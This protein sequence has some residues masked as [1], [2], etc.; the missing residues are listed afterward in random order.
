MYCCLDGVD[1]TD[2]VSLVCN[3][4]DLDTIAND[5]FEASINTLVLKQAK[6][7]DPNYIIL[8]KLSVVSLVL[9]EVNANQDDQFSTIWKA[10][11]PKLQYITINKMNMNNLDD[12]FKWQQLERYSK[13]EGI[14]VK[15]SALNVIDVHMSDVLSN[16][17]MLHT[18]KIEGKIK[19]INYLAFK[20]SDDLNLQQLD[21]SNNIISNLRWLTHSSLKHLK[22]LNLANNKLL[23]LPEQLSQALPSLQQ[24]DLS[25]NNFRFITWLAIQPLAALN[26]VR[27]F[28]QRQIAPLMYFTSEMSWIK[29]KSKFDQLKA[30]FLV[31][32]IADIPQYMTNFGKSQFKHF[33]DHKD[34]Q[35]SYYLDQIYMESTKLGHYDYGYPEDKD[36]KERYMFGGDVVPCRHED[37]FQN[38]LD[39]G[40]CLKNLKHSSKLK[41]GDANVKQIFQVSSIFTRNHYDFITTS[42]G[43]L[44]QGKQKLFYD[45]L[46]ELLDFAASIDCYVIVSLWEDLDSLTAPG[47]VNI[48]V[49]KVRLNQLLQ[50]LRERI[51]SHPALLGFDVGVLLLKD[52]S[53]WGEG[54]GA[55]LE[56]PETVNRMRPQLSLISAV[57]SEL[58]SSRPVG[59]SIGG[60]CGSCFGVMANFQKCFDGFEKDIDFINIIN[61]DE[62]KE[63]FNYM[64]YE[65]APNWYQRAGGPLKITFFTIHNR[66]LFFEAIEQQLFQAGTIIGGFITHRGTNQKLIT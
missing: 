65:E 5:P 47:N 34:D 21:M 20:T 40:Q 27:L 51:S 44:D 45:E 14:Y 56:K 18:I 43:V 57:I 30:K 2:A 42:D 46:E 7:E 19:N 11:D 3:I 48:K 10:F 35:L 62:K 4:K 32:S 61:D 16:N 49:N 37:F 26:E 54:L 22:L 55:C 12:Q 50:Q 31:E 36:I 1:G 13:L 52:A 41:L 28:S 53:P 15:D 59:V 58:S 17:P 63:K 25:A 38:T 23:T 39:E 66:G 24:L 29:D 64:L 60:D 33:T 9:D 6:L 8:P